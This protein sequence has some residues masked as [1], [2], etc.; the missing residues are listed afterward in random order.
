MPNRDRALWALA[1]LLSLA[2]L[3]APALWNGFALLQYD[4]G[5]YLARWYEGYLVPSRAV[6]YGLMLV[7]GAP[8]AFWPVLLLQS[9]ATV[10]MLA[11]TLRA[12]G[13]GR[14]PLLLLA[15]IA[16]LSLLTTLPWLTV[17]PAHRHFLRPRGA[18]ALSV[19]VAPRNAQPPRT[20][21]LDPV[22]RGRRRHPQRNARRAARAPRRC[23]PAAADRSAAHG[24]RQSRPRRAGACAR[25]RSRARRRLCRGQAA[26]LDAGRL[27]AV[28]R[29][30]V[31]GRH[32]QKISRP[33]LSRSRAAI[34]RLQGS[35]SA[36]TPTSGS[37]AAIC[38]T[39]SA[40]SPASAR[41]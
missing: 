32:R 13:L 29:P 9:A 1:V 30:H 40:A 11:L 20:R 21:R 18:G 31:A 16:A 36:P 41:K 6:V 12:H 34:V 37:G 22:G 25:R 8:L 19:D 4:T 2:L 27:R 17:D 33:A 28:V 5:G 39:G 15:V 7:A 26:G 35:A 38:S 23:R 10:W 14:R 24:T 3:M